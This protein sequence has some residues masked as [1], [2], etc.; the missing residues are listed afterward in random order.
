M[1]ASIQGAH[2]ITFYEAFVESDILYIVTEPETHGDLLAYLK[3]A[4]RRAR[5][6]RRR[7]GRSSSR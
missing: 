2:V 4:R 7:C 6:P 5:C 3:N 1:L